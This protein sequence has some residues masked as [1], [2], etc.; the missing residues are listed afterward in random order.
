MKTYYWRGMPNFGDLLGPLLLKHFT[1]ME[2][3]W[4]P[5]EYA[6]I[7]TVGS[8][9]EHVLPST[10]FN[11]VIAG[12]GF[13]KPGSSIKF[14]GPVLSV[15]GPL[16]LSRIVS[17][18]RNIGMGDPGLLANELVGDQDKQY[19]LG[20]VPHWSDN[21]LAKNPLF[22]KYNPLIINVQDDPLTVIRQIGSCRKIVSSSLHGIVLADAFGI[23]RRIEMAPSMLTSPHEGGTYKWEDYSASL[24]MKLEIGITQTPDRNKVIERQH[25]IFDVFEEVKSIFAKTTGL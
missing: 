13:L 10:H 4:S 11:G 23:P 25:E 6:S 14:L 24:D 19:H 7:I 15:R 2:A 22:L 17:K 20:V 1:Y 12:A 5:R 9:L 8:I 16:S 21:V 3:K 18:R